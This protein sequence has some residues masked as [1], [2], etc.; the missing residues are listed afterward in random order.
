MFVDRLGGVKEIIGRIGVE[1]REK[2]LKDREY[3]VCTDTKYI[4]LGGFKFVLHDAGDEKRN[5]VKGTRKAGETNRAEEV[6]TVYPDARPFR[7]A[8]SLFSVR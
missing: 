2:D 3:H 1:I 7:R 6:Y 4:H 8:R 5:Y